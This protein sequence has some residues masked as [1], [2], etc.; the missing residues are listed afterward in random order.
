[1]TAPAPLFTCPSCGH[2]DT[3]DAFVPRKLTSRFDEYAFV[4]LALVALLAL[5]KG[6]GVLAVVRSKRR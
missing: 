2:T 4:G 3:P 1:M 5:L 6:I